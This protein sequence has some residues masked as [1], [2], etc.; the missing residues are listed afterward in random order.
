MF[1][2]RATGGLHGKLKNSPPQT[3]AFRSKACQSE[4]APGYT[5]LDRW[6]YYLAHRFP[7]VEEEKKKTGLAIE[8]AATKKPPSFSD[9][10]CP[11]ELARNVAPELLLLLET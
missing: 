7:H 4:T 8:K 6:Y 11:A 1:H 3:K 10:L 5:N 9:R 2:I